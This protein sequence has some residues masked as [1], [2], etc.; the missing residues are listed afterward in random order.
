MSQTDLLRCPLLCYLPRVLSERRW[1]PRTKMSS[2]I[3][4]LCKRVPSFLCE[5]H[6]V[7]G[8]GLSQPWRCM[9]GFASQ[10]SAWRVT[11][12]LK[13]PRGVCPPPASD[14]TVPVAD[15]SARHAPVCLLPYTCSTFP[16]GSDQGVPLPENTTP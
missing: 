11:E 10:R 4:H 5:P 14:W 1:G 8:E 3:I 16:S 12:A 6:W 2:V 9:C 15:P 7:L 13:G